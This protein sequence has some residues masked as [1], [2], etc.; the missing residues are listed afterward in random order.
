MSKKFL[1]GGCPGNLQAIP[2]LVE[3]MTVSDVAN[4]LEKPLGEIIKKLML[5]GIMANI[6]SSI[7]FTTAELV[8]EELGVKL[9]Q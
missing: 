6:N 2:K 9:E 8:A 3:G 7:D 5:L 1:G 4:G